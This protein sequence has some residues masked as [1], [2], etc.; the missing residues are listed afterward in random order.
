MKIKQLLIKGFGIFLVAFGLFFTLAFFIAISES[1]YTSTDGVMV[2]FL[3]LIPLGLGSW[4]IFLANKNTKLQLYR[5]M[6]RTVLELAKKSDNKLTALEL[7]SNTNMSVKESTDL[8][9]HFHTEGYAQISHATT[10]AIIYEFPDLLSR[11]Q[12]NNSTPL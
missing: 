3:G 12:K 1:G 4:L 10:G 6:E 2:I 8:L 9:N 7:A 5:E 11:N